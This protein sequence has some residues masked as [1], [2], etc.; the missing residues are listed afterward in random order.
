M[1]YAPCFLVFVFDVCLSANRKKLGGC[2]PLYSKDRGLVETR[3]P[4]GTTLS[5]KREHG[6]EHRPS[7]YLMQPDGILVKPSRSLFPPCNLLVDNTSI[8][9]LHVRDAAP[10]GNKVDSVSSRRGRALPVHIRLIPR[11]KIV[12]RGHCRR[13]G[14]SHGNDMAHVYLDAVHPQLGAV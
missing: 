10:A 3:A 11:R 14:V 5:E 4:H 8:Y 9:L 6:S 7:V 12:A 2:F 13:G 1:L